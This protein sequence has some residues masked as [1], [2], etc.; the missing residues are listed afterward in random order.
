MCTECP[1]VETQLNETSNQSALILSHRPS[2]SDDFWLQESRDRFLSVYGLWGYPTLTI[3]GHYILA[4]PTQSRE[5]DELLFESI[6]NYSGITNV[7]LDNDNLTVE[8]SFDGLVIDVWTVTSTSK[9]TNK[10]TNHTNLSETNLVDVDGEKLVIVISQPG[11]IT[12]V[13]GSS[14]PAN[15]YIPEG[16][17]DEIVEKGNSVKGSTVIIITVLLMII[18]LPATYQLVQVIRSPPSIEEE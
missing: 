7:S 16:G 13:P 18:T 1:E 12:L 14:M 6:S 15:D 9:L 5:L 11:F 8:G 2:S 3:D 10:V 17:L 4:G